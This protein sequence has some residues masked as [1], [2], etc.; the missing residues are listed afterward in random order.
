MTTF[1]IFLVFLVGFL[2]GVAVLLSFPSLPSWAGLVIG[3]VIVILAAVVAN[4]I[5]DT[6]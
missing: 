3:S 1:R 6:D 4:R 2:I 5:N